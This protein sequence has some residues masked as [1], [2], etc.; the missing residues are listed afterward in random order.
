MVKFNLNFVPE[1]EFAALATKQLTALTLRIPMINKK[2]ADF[3]RSL[4]L[5]SPCSFLPHKTLKIK[6]T[7]TNTSQPSL[8]CLQMMFK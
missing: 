7:I 4:L 5:V 3:H 2:L 8:S 1:F 6:S